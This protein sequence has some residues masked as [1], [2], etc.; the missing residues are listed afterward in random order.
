MDTN[1]Q[2]LKYETPNLKPGVL[3][4]DITIAADYA[5]VPVYE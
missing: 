4:E 5:Q 3:I 2:T 1:N